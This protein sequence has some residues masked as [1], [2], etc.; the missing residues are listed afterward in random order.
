MD[1]TRKRTVNISATLH[2]A[3]KIRCAK[4]EAQIESFITKALWLHLNGAIAKGV[5]K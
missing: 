3:I 4:E 2:Q 1:T 5:V